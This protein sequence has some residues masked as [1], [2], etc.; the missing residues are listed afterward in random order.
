[1]FARVTTVQVQADKV[2][3][4]LGTLERS[5]LPAAEQ[6]PGY[7][8]YLLLTDRVAG[9]AIGITL[10]E[11]AEARE[12]GASNAGSYQEQM[13]R[14]AQYFT[15]QPTVENYDVSVQV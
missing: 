1:M 3:E 12:A 14:L 8:G 6:Q 10:W 5:L 15:G 7:K 13:G 11:S 2:D 9:R 4:A